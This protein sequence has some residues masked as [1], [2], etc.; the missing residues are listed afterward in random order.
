MATMVKA[1]RYEII[2]ELGR[3]AMGVVYRAMDPVIGR[4]VAVKT[5]RLSEE[6]TGL[7][8]PELLA[9]FQ[10]EA[11]AA[12]LLTHPNIV[13][14]Y[15]AGEENG[16]YFITMELVEG[17][18]LQA[19]LD[20]GHAF[21]VPRVIRIMEQTCSALQFAHERNIVHRDVKPA[22]LML[23]A[24]DTVKV[25]DFGTAKILQFGTVQQTAHVMGTPSYMSPEQ[26]KGRPVDGRSDIFSIGVMLYEMLTG[27]K[28]FPG[29][30]ITTV[31]YKIVNEEP[32]PPRQINP[33]IHPGL[34][35]IVLRAL[36]KEP[37]N[38]YQSCR[39]LLEDLRNYRAMGG[40][41]RNPDATMISPR[42]G[43]MLPLNAEAGGQRGA[44]I[45]DSMTAATVRSLQ[46]R[47]GGPGQ[48]PAVRRTGAVRPIEPPK[49]KNTLA[50]VLA[51]LFLVGVIIYGGNM[52]RPEFQAAR[53]RNNSS[54][55]D[56][57]PD[58]A[59]AQSPVVKDIRV[60]SSAATATVTGP[61]TIPVPAQTVSQPASSN[62]APVE[63]PKPAAAAPAVTPEKKQNP[64]ATKMVADKKPET[65][66]NATALEYKGRIEEAIADRGLSGR[67]MIAGIGNTLTL[68]GKLR[69]AE[70]GSLLRFM[71]DAPGAVHI[72]DDILYDDTPLA[73]PGA[74]QAEGH[75]IPAKGL[76]AVHVLTDVLGARATLFGPGGHSLA[77]CQTPC[78]FNN[79]L[80]ERYSLQVRKDGYLQVQT[81]LALKAGESQDQKI[82][83]EALA[84]GVYIRSK[85]PGADIFINGAKQSGQT[86]TTLPLAPGHYDLVLRLQGYAP[87]VG[88]VQV[89]DNI[90]TTLEAEL[91]ERSQTH[92]AWAQVTTTPAGA[93]III[94]G[95]S[96]GQF[97]P[98]RVQI[99]AGTHVIALK[100]SG[101]QAVRRGVEVSEGS[102]V[103]VT[104]ELKRK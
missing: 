32:I 29:Q 45:E 95:I 54:Q 42:P 27:E 93:E 100:L 102:T 35:D 75:P 64:P 48:T 47:A 70:H 40:N 56:V 104:E 24:D 98:S 34:N 5:I 79:L 58:G 26:V 16:L 62:P 18:S 96:T 83:L 46:N 91:K 12:G 2:D 67:V 1:G 7:T 22:N 21:P 13:V 38:R 72:V 57:L 101:F 53:V 28:P 77:D 68:S 4:T 39:E 36:A 86:P 51:A 59:V 73:A 19:L 8:R 80:P 63:E 88:E 52:L 6:G 89:K 87:Y 33:S 81:A 3:G 23:T 31:I 103:P 97:S 94:D 10:T 78:S 49:K 82:H 92:V 30:S 69:P 99:A 9:R 44:Y 90:Q 85:P 20:G 55:R 50:T 74:G 60:D 17:K 37:E 71:H 76:S 65:A 11:R 15:D 84:K 43:A 14:V 66:L 25:T 41:E 61:T